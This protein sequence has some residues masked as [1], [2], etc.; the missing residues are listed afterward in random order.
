MPE[1]V[2]IGFDWSMNS[3]SICIHEGNEWSFENCSFKYFTGSKRCQ[4]KSDKLSGWPIPCYD[5]RDELNRWIENSRWAG[6]RVAHHQVTY[7]GMEGYSYGSKGS[8]PFSI[9][10]NTAILKYTLKQLFPEIPL[11]IFS[12][13]SIKK[14]ATGKG[15][16]D[17]TMMYEAFV[18]DTWPFDLTKIILSKPDGNPISDIVDSYFIAKLTFY[19]FTKS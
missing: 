18:K 11:N 4:V 5:E 8:L 3:P 12:P 2:T 16:A 10:E 7:L 14:F 9:A 1:K 19:E 6:A 15:N 13:G 17:K